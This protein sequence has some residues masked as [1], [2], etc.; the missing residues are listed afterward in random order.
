[1]DIREMLR[2][3]RAGTS[4]RGVQQATGID[5]RTVKKYREWTAERGLLE[6][7]LPRL[8]ELQALIAATLE[9]PPPPQNTS[10]VEPYAD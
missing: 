3:I 9:S 6:G 10:T 8:E 7:E 4:D 2:Q 1:M 5:R